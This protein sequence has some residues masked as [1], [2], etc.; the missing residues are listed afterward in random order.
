MATILGSTLLE[1]QATPDTLGKYYQCW[2][3]YERVF[4]LFFYLYHDLYHGYT[5][6]MT[7]NSYFEECKMPPIFRCI[8]LCMSKKKI[9]DIYDCKASLIVRHI[10]ISET[11]MLGKTNPRINEKLWYFDHF[12]EIPW[13]ISKC[14]IFFSSY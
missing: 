1:T 7:K 10:P 13:M 6:T 3:S 14:H 5:I 11:K 8:I 12:Q 2:E 9:A 4:I